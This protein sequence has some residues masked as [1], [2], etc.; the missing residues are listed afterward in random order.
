M[1]QLS[2]DKYRVMSLHLK[3]YSISILPK[4]QGFRPAYS[5]I[6]QKKL[7]KKQTKK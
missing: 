1:P 3:T 5:N 2:M 4:N 6:V 7:P